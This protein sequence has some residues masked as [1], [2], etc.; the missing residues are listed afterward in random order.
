MSNLGLLLSPGFL[1]RLHKRGGDLRKLLP[2][3]TLQDV[4]AHKARTGSQRHA[5][6]LDEGI[7]GGDSNA[8]GGD[9]LELRHGGEDILDVLRPELVGREYLH[10]IRTRFEVLKRDAE[11]DYLRAVLAGGEGP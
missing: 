8:T 7:H 9:D 10:E 1:D 2:I 3:L 11:I 6:G 5:S 4:F